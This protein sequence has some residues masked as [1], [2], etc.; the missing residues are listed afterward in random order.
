H[1]IMGLIVLFFGASGVFV[2][3]QDA[4]NTIW[5]V[6]PRPGRGVIQI[7]RDR[8]L[9]FAMVMSI[10]FL[11]L[12]SLAVTA[13]LAALRRMWTP[14][15]LPGGEWLWQGINFLVSFGVITLL[16]ALILKVLPDAQ[17]LWGDVWIGAAVT[18]L[19]FTLGKFLLGLY[20][21]RGGVT[22]GYGPAG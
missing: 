18:S 19:L 14:S 3:L 12:A 17:V 4:M 6:A 22:S 1:T 13:F 2:E 9:S 8:F 5:Q 11:L 21:G 16:F 7:I 20:L 15:S 10:C